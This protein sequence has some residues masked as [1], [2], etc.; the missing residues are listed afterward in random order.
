MSE[1]SEY[2][3]RYAT[4]DMERSDGVLQLTFHTDGGPLQ[5][6][7][8]G[9]SQTE[10][11]DAFAL[12][13]RDPEN[14]VVIMTGTG[15][16]FAGPPASEA[17]FVSGGPE[18]WEVVR[19]DGLRLMFNLLDIPVPVIACLNGPAYRHADIALLG[20]IVLAADHALIQDTAHFLNHT[21]PGDGLHLVLLTLLG[22][23]RGRHLMLTG[24]SLDARELHDL[25]LV[26]EVL[27]RERLLPR[28]HELAA[29]IASR[30]PLV[31]RYTRM[32]LVEPLK[33]LFYR[34]LPH[35]WALEAMAAAHENTERARL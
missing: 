9:K 2:Q 24:R 5:W 8:T 34:S 13:A 27:P 28:A 3:H 29:T 16:I 32:A 4:I 14:R 7:H 12:L 30:S 22:W 15:D 11:A 18:R 1:L 25:G 21:V 23:N 10:F 26:A 31:L 35:S 33:Q 19:G 20:D 6:G 17:T